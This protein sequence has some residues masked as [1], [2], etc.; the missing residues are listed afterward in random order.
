M[1][2]NK[3]NL[4]R[5]N[6]KWMVMGIVAVMVILLGVWIINFK[7]FINP[8]EIKPITAASSSLS[9]ADLK[10]QF[11]NTMNQINVKLDVNDVSKPAATSST[12]NGQ[13]QSLIA[14]LSD[15][16]NSTT[17]TTTASTTASSSDIQAAQ[18]K[19]KLNDLQSQ[20]ERNNP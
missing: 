6:H 5:Q 15:Q 4:D 2:N 13:V 20:L 11:D 12:D 18:I 19:N 10:S 3:K 16:V 8:H 7:S 1:K 9:W 17:S 14:N